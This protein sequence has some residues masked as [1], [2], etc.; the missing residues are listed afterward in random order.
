MENAVVFTV[1]FEHRFTHLLRKSSDWFLYDSG[2]RH[3]ELRPSLEPFVFK[4]QCTKKI[5][6]SIKDFFSKCGQIRRK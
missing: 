6:F 4:S 2:L 3:K 1:N 5:K